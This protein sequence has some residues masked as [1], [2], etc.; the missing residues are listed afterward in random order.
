MLALGAYQWLAQVD[1]SGLVGEGDETNNLG[2]GNVV[3]VVAPPA[4]LFVL[5]GPS[6]ATEVNLN[7]NYTVTIDFKNQGS[8]PT[9]NV[10]DVVVYLSADT[11][12]D[13]TDVEVGRSTISDKIFENTTRTLQLSA[14][15]PQT[16]PKGSFR[17]LA[18]VDAANSEGESDENNNVG[19]GNVTDVVE[20]LADLVV[21][22]SPSGPNGVFR[23]GAYT[24]TTE[25]KNQGTG[26]NLSDFDVVI[27]LSEDLIVGNS[28]DVRVGDV[29]VSSVLGVD[30]TRAVDV[31]VTIPALQGY[32][33][34]QWVAVVDDVGFVPELNETNNSLIGLAVS[35]VPSPSDLVIENVIS[36]TPVERG[37]VY[38]VSLDVVNIGDGLTTGAFQVSLFMTAD[39][40]VG[41]ADDIR[42]GNTTLTDIL[43]PNDRK[44]LTLSI[45]I[46]SL[47]AVGTYKL[48]ALADAGRIETETDET[49]NATFSS[50]P[51]DVVPSPP[52]LLFVTD[53]AGKERVFRG[54]VDTVNVQ[55]RNQGIGDANGTF[56]VFVF[57]SIDGQPD[58]LD[59]QVGAWPVSQSILAGQ[60]LDVAIPIVIP[61]EQPLGA[62]R[63][64]ARLDANKALNESDETNNDR[65]GVAVSVVHFPPDVTIFD[66]IITPAQVAR[67][68]IYQISV[69]VRNVGTGPATLGF[70]VE[71]FL[72]ED[73]HLTEVDV[74]AG[75]RKFA[76]SFGAGAEEIT[77]VSVS[78]P[79]DLPVASYRWIARVAVVGLQDESDVGNNVRLGST[80]VF[81]VMVVEP[82]SL[83]FGL[84][85]VGETRS[86][87]FEVL[88]GGTARL[89]FEIDVTDPAV[90]VKPKS[91]QDLPPGVPWIVMVT[92]APEI[93]GTLSATL[94][95]NSN[96]LD[97]GQVVALSGLGESP[98]ED[99]ISLQ[100]EYDENKPLKNT[101]NTFGHEEVKMSV[102]MTDVPQLRQAIFTVH[103][104]SLNMVYV[105]SSWM[106]DGL[107]LAATAYSANQVSPGVLEL[108]IQSPDILG[109]G[110][111][112]LGQLTFRSTS[113]FTPGNTA[114]ISVRKFQHQTADTAAV[115][116]EV[117]GVATLAYDLVCWA[118]IH[119]DSV[120]EIRDFL[121]FINAF[122]RASGDVGWVGELAELPSPQTPYQRFDANSDGR[123][124]LSDFLL[125]TQVFG[126]RCSR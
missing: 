29:A 71:V 95:I 12:H 28:D 69:P 63:W 42:V 19:I 39:D 117:I 24:V 2:V 126:Q 118:D 96:D 27:F 45:T 99:R 21:S 51:I 79:I 98:E 108:Q 52:D 37:N 64:W 65:V 121:T 30:S 3:Q 23:R 5:T 6:G 75:G 123:V 106:P 54:V 105:D 100:F 50:V 60:T 43:S 97:G 86:L 34:Y 48:F 102:V 92:Y 110:T 26:S 115:S 119:G 77:L 90:S 20:K 10:F 38:N 87:T 35:V 70:Q 53:P 122:D 116:T 32:R 101:Y 89:S 59:V 44:A 72:S 7:G 81:P 73:E 112:L 9:Q 15:V 8:G 94:G 107:F 74:L 88:N 1:V 76:E 120:V 47:Q 58:S 80:V 84:V 11:L 125:F 49:N 67:G 14:V 41:N 85:R 78:I 83:D 55:V 25:I 56:D 68:G 104:D 18:V 36:S 62:Y 4:D 40:S 124:N 91:V 22:V 46:P 16:H 93:T 13:S 33:S 17:W 114:E 103:Y 113:S 82:I 61:T 66:E 31:R 57:L 109:G 111:G